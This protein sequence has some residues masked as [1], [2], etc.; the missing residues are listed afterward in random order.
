MS[1]SE[2]AES[3]ALPTSLVSIGK[4][5]ED[6]ISTQWVV[7]ILV[8]ILIALGSIFFRYRAKKV[9]GF[10]SADVVVGF[11][12]GLTA[13]LT[14]F[15][16]GFVLVSNTASEVIPS[17]RQHY[18]VGMFVLLAMFV[19]G[20][21]FGAWAMHKFGWDDSNPPKVK[22]AGFTPWAINAVGVIYLVIAFVVT[23]GAF[24]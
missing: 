4:F 16:S 8:P 19:G 14:L 11:D 3:S 18:I 15:V 1:Q 6:A 7:L 5:L 20:L 23:G 22:V 2:A 10:E 13:C 21:F 17:D 24:K 12:L 9:C